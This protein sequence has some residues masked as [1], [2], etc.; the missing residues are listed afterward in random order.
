MTII[1]RPA[2]FVLVSSGH[3]TMIANIEGMELE[4]L[5]CADRSLRKF[6]PQLLIEWIKSD[7]QALARVLDGYGYRVYEVGINL[8]ALH[9][10]DESNSQITI[11]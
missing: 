4:A 5:G 11:T 9:V 10:T 8:L 6:K 3:G 2:P 1:R 7:K